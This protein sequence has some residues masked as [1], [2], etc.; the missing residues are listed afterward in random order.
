MYPVT[1]EP[2]LSAGAV[3]DTVTCVFPPTPDTAVGAPGMVAGVT[4]ADEPGV[5]LPMSLVAMTVNVYATPL[6]RPDTMQLV[7]A[8]VQVFVAPLTCGDAD[9]V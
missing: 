2:P 1:A 7:V 4:A 6:V 3:Q 9:T 5:L 8:E